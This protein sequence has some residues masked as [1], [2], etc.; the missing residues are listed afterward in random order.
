M[1]AGHGMNKNKLLKWILINLALYLTYGFLRMPELI[2][3]PRIIQFVG[4]IQF[5]LPISWLAII[6]FKNTFSITKKYLF[7]CLAIVPW[8]IFLYVFFVLSY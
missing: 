1:K 4:V 5:F 6:S 3:L 7:L 8:I 2:E